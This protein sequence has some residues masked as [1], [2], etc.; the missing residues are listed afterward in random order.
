MK[1]QNQ[2][3]MKKFSSIV[4]MFVSFFGFTQNYKGAIQKIKEDGLHQIVINPEIRASANENLGFLRIKDGKQNEVPYV[5]A[6]DS[7]KSWST[8]VPFE[9]VSRNIIKDSI[10]SIVVENK[11]NSKLNQI[12]LK[13]A[14]TSISKYYSISGSND[15][16][17]WFGLVENQRLTAMNVTAA[18]TVEKSISFPVNSYKYLKIDCNDKSTLPINIL[19]IGQYKHHFLSQELIEIEGL[20]YTTVENKQRKVTQIV[21]PLDKNYQIDAISFNIKTELYVRDAKL[22]VNR[23]RKIKKRTEKHEEV[24]STFQ[25]NSKNN[26]VFYFDDLKEKELIIEIENKDNQALEIENI[27]LLQKPV[28]LISKLNANQ[29]YQVFIDSTYSKPSYD[30]IN[31]I[32]DSIY[33]LPEAKITNFQKV[34]DDEINPKEKSFWKTQLFMW[35]CIVLGGGI[36]AYFAFGLLKDMK[37]E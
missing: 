11:S 30:L 15:K 8:Y 23:E 6:F 3:Q 28:Y 29:N 33:N 25:L 10:T 24:I 19:D 4:V 27:H 20:N 36:V 21:F 32:S 16:D 9:I 37:N 35:I 13:I 12:L 5:I 34:V 1:H 14:N 22:I 31:F 26:S 2:N 7:D 18:T 17:D